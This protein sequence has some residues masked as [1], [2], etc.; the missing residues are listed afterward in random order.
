MYFRVYRAT[1]IG[2]IKSNSEVLNKARQIN[3]KHTNYNHIFSYAL[4]T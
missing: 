2:G 1:L 3:I 4:K